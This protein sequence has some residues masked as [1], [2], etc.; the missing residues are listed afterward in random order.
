MIAR[1]DSL[2]ISPK[3]GI[4][5]LQHRFYSSLKDNGMTLEE[6]ENVKKKKNY[7]TMKRKDLG[8]LNKIY[9]F[10]DT[11]ILYEILEQRP[12]KLRR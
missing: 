9:Y 3:D 2:D 11:I 7:Q 12:E 8:G 10:Q 6:Y 5:F 4:F 1:Y